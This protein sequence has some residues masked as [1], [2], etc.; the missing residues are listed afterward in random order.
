[1][2]F[3]LKEKSNILRVHTFWYNKAMKKICAYIISFTILGGVLWFTSLSYKKLHTNEK[4]IFRQHN[5]KPLTIPEEYCLVQKGEL[6]FSENSQTLCVIDNR[7][8]KVHEF[9]LLRMNEKQN[10]TQEKNK[11]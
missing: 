2:F 5:E 7:E 4:L 8:V 9:M 10:L 1:L 11:H 3:L 6:L